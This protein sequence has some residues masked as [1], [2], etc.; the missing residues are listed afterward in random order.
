MKELKI[1]SNVAISS[2][3]SF[4][5]IACVVSLPPSLSL[6]SNIEVQLYQQERAPTKTKSRRG[7]YLINTFTQVIVSDIIL[8]DF[9]LNPK[10][11]TLKKATLNE[12]LKD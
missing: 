12:L 6:K 10:N 3:E 1:G 5:I 2:D 4:P 8:Y 11:K 7:F 9:E